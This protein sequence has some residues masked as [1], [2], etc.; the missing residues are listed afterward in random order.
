MYVR[1]PFRPRRRRSRR[2]SALIIVL[3]MLSVLLLMS[4]AFSTFTRTERSGST[5]V[6]NAQV[7]RA[8]MQSA[9]AH[10]VEAID[11]SFDSPANNW[12]VACWPH[13]F[14]SS[15]EEPSDDFL[16]SARLGDK[17]TANA[18]VLTA[19]IAENLTPA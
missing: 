13:P 18:H 4:V 6:K 16:Q 9:V 8:A 2:G 5:N 11:L 15:S 14:L 12:P 10:V 7:A 3:G 17:E 1:F 19:E